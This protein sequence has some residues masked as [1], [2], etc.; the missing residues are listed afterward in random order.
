MFP[1]PA[2]VGVQTSDFPAV[3]V[4]VDNW[5]VGSI[6]VMALMDA[7]ARIVMLTVEVRLVC[8]WAIAVMVTMF[9]APVGWTAGAVYKPLVSIVP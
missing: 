3:A 2:T 5:V 6:H 4:V 9:S 1:P 8:A 7:G